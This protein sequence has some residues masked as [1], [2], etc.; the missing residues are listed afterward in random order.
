M[1]GTVA[2]IK[3]LPG[4]EA[5]MM[6]LSKEY[7]GL[8]LPGHIATYVYKLDGA[9]DEYIMAV[10]FDSRER[11]HANAQSPEQHTRFERMRALMAADPQWA[12]GEVIY[13]PG[14]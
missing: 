11:Y 2:R 1:Y 7:E 9:E 5:E 6:R 14:R 8:G 4:A 13:A 10:L 12:D 3:L